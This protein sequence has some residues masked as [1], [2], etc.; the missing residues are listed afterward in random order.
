MCS[1]AAFGVRQVSLLVSF[2]NVVMN[3]SAAV[4]CHLCQLAEYGCHSF[5]QN[6]MFVY[7]VESR[8]L[9]LGYHE[10]CEVRSVYL[11]QKYLLIA[12]FNH[13]LGLGLFYKTKLLQLHIN[14]H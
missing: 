9:E 6:K 2:Q 10:L 7:T 12:F 5:L 4:I 8:Y 11:N 13:N 1:V 3:Y 14:L